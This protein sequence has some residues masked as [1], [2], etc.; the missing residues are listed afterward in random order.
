MQERNLSPGRK[1][2]RVYSLGS[3][4]SVERNPLQPRRSQTSHAPSVASAGLAHFWIS[5]FSHFAPLS[6]LRSACSSS[7]FKLHVLPPTSH[8]ASTRKTKKSE[9]RSRRWSK[10]VHTESS[11]RVEA[12]PGQLARDPSIRRS[13]HLSNARQSVH[14]LSVTP[15]DLSSIVT[16]V[17]FESFPYFSIWDSFRQPVTDGGNIEGHFD[18]IVFEVSE[19]IRD[20]FF[21]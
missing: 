4:C 5:P 17:T 7:L 10:S 15:S 8:G 19:K 13:R 14:G 6:R 1:N 20:S 21:G 2:Q 12:S 11:S 3:V 9:R 16:I 18:S